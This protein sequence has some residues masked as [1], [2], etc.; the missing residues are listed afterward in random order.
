MARTVRVPE[1]SAAVDHR[2]VRMV[3]VDMLAGG[4]ELA[5]AAGVRPTDLDR[6]LSLPNTPEGAIV[7]YLGCGKIYDL[8]IAGPWCAQKHLSGGRA[9]ASYRERQEAEAGGGGRRV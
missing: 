6:K 8:R 7:A 9:H 2:G 3:P 1:G 5:R 4:V